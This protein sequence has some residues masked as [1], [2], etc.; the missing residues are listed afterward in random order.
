MSGIHVLQKASS[1][2]RGGAVV[3]IFMRDTSAQV[4][5]VDT[6]DKVLLMEE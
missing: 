6:V 2:V 1:A 5:R 3:P 4:G